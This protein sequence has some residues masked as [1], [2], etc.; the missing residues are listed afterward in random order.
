MPPSG[1]LRERA[2]VRAVFTAEIGK[3][4][5]G[6][7]ILSGTLVAGIT[8]TMAKSLNAGHASVVL[9]IMQM[10]FLLTGILSVIFLK[11]KVTAMKIV[12]L[13]L[14]VAAVLLLSLK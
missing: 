13:L 7:G 8:V 11:E 3:K 2:G 10:S 9:P 1:F 6:Y 14:G 4:L 12:A 5:V